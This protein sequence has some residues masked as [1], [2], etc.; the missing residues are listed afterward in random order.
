[1]AWHGL[2]STRYALPTLLAALIA[3]LFTERVVTYRPPHAGKEAIGV[4]CTLTYEGAVP[5]ADIAPGQWARACIFNA[6]DWFH[7]PAEF[8][9]LERIGVTLYDHALVVLI[10]SRGHRQVLA[11][12]G[13]QRRPEELFCSDLTSSSRIVKKDV[14]REGVVAITVE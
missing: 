11:L 3:A 6:D 14:L 7:P 1:M 8:K 4:E 9:D 12:R 2:L 10:D 13:Y 5:I